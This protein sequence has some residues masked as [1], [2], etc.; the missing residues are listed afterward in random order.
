MT[1]IF[2]TEV[3]EPDFAR[4]RVQWEAALLA[5][6][7]ARTVCL[8]DPDQK[9]LLRA[10][11]NGLFNAASF[12]AEGESEGSGFLDWRMSGPEQFDLIYHSAH[13]LT[14]SLGRVYRQPSGTWGALVIA[15]V[16]DDPAA[17]MAAA[18]WA[19]ARLSS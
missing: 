4:Y 16:K 12:A 17:A 9:E 14:C 3:R 1:T 11:V 13:G 15:G 7:V 2:P 19:I 6:T 10:W 18:E 5:Q 8:E